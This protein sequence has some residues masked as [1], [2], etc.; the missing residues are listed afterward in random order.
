MRLGKDA[1]LFLEGAE[2]FD[3][4]RPTA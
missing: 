4:H 3:V 1:V 2:D